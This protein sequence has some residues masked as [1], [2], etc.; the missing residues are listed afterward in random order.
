GYQAAVMTDLMGLFHTN[1]IDVVILNRATP[2]L[3]NEVVKNGIVL[4]C[5]DEEARIRFEVRT[6]QKY[7]DTKP[8]REIQRYYLM[9]RIKHGTLTREI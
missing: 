1:D 9:E 6:L 7:V 4:F 3:A 8:L 5:R 2:L